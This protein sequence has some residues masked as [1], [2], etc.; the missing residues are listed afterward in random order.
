MSIP[1]RVQ[2]DDVHLNAVFTEPTTRT[3][4]K[5]GENICISLGK[6]K[7]YFSD[8]QDVSFSG[9]Y[10]DLIDKPEVDSVLSTT[11]TN[12]IQNSAVAKIL[13]NTYTTG[14][15]GTAATYKAKMKSFFDLFDANNLTDTQLTELCEVWYEK[16][17]GSWNGWTTFPV[18]G[19]S[20]GVRGGDN[21]GLVCSPST[22][23]TA[24]QDDF[25]GLPLFYPIDVNWYLDSN[26]DTI[27]SGI[28]GITASFDRYDPDKF[29]GVMQ[30]S[31]YHWE[32][33][34]SDTF[35]HGY[36]ANYVGGKTYCEPLP[37]CYHRDGTFKQFMVH[38]KYMGF[39]DSNGYMR[40]YSGVM[41][42]AWQGVDTAET[43]CKKH[44]NQ[45]GSESIVTLSFLK[46][47]SFIKY[48][49]LTQDGINQG[50][51]QYNFQYPA[52]FSETGVNR[53]ILTDAQ[54]DNLIVGSG[55]LI[56]TVGASN[57]VDRG[58]ASV[59]GVLG[60]T[61]TGQA[62]AIITKKEPYTTS[63]YTCV[64][65]E[66][67]AQNFNTTAGTSL[68]T[69]TT[70]I[71][72]FT[73][74]T[75]ANDNILGNDG[76][77]SS[78][79][80]GVYPAKIQ[81]IEYSTGIYDLYGDIIIQ[82]NPET[83]AYTNGFISYYVCPDSTKRSTTAITTD[84]I[85]TGIIM[86]N[87]AATNWYYI[88]EQ[89]FGHGICMPTSI[90]GGSSTTFYRDSFYTIGKQTSTQIRSVRS[91]AYLNSGVGHGG[92]SAVA[93]HHVLSSRSWLLGARL[94]ATPSWKDVAT[95]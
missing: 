62:G 17:R 29:V 86:A 91:F 90:T 8:L 57:N 60:S 61:G 63:G 38:S 25:A 31:A 68:T 85:D 74:P 4:L 77:I 64:Y 89:K 69:G 23:T 15:D 12:A 59:Y 33:S 22:N 76:A 66:N 49:S 20:Y 13:L 72:T 80:D 40:C 56:G 5:S 82:Y 55:V 1:N 46:L 21:A 95:S 37:E 19:V 32:E 34:D 3:N 93:G 24:E 73:W 10:N 42:T 18:S 28:D 50:C 92:L 53:V 71:S 75:G 30:M 51:L 84:Y 39:V 94:S 7:K 47:M 88:S 11:S 65:V 6:I 45:Y 36:S 27:I 78:P 2:K 14:F 26:G 52:A 70:I 35:T 16:T 9:S 79:G 87:T 54:A 81:G 83:S 58:T 48:A 67:I 43:A 44:S 41:P